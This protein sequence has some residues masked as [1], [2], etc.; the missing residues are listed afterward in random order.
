MI[1]TG[2]Y[3]QT[4]NTDPEKKK[5]GYGRKVDLPPPHET[6][7]VTNF[8]NV[9]GWKDHETPLAPQGFSVTRYADGFDNPRWIYVAPNGDVLVAESNSHHPFFER[10]GGYIIGAGRSNHLGKS[11]DRITLLR[12]LDNDGVVDEH[13]TFIEALNQPFGMLIIDNWFYVANTDAIWR[14]P[15]KTGQRALDNTAGEKIA[16]LP[17]GKNNRHWTRNIIASKDGKKLYVAI[18][19]GSNVGENGLDEEVL[20]ANILVMNIDGSD[21]KVYAAGLRNPVG[22]AFA[23]GTNKLWTV[24]NERDELGDDLVPDY[25]TSVEEGGFYGWPYTYFGEHIDARVKQPRPE[26]I[27][28]TIV[29]DVALGSHTA[30]L[31]LVI[32][33]N[34]SYPLRYR[35]G[36]FIAQ[37]GSWNRSVLSGYRVVFVPFKDGRPSG[38]PEDF[39]TGFVANLEKDKVHGRPVGLVVLDDGSLLIADDVSNAIWRVSPSKMTISST[40]D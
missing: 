13:D 32:V 15:Y 35:T 25:L 17:A 3:A 4:Y 18:G 36:A 7:S 33:D 2:S 16:D 24:V 37:H 8:S 27:K 31:G 21:M 30:S 12:D 38:E 26:S 10:I 34:P 1:C 5:E 19:S 20:K 39:L 14:F 11:A 6:K 9:I 23:P 28:E 40:G 22:M 29:P